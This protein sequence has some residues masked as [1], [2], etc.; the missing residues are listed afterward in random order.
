MCKSLAETEFSKLLEKMDATA[1]AL[2]DMMA[3]EYSNIITAATLI[4]NSGF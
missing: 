1:I 3:R 2:G 4:C